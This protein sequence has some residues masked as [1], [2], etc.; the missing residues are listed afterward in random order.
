MSGFLQGFCILYLPLVLYLKTGFQ[1]HHSRPILRPLSNE[2]KQLGGGGAGGWGCCDPGD[3]RVRLTEDNENSIIC[4]FC[5]L[6]FCPSFNR[7]S[8]KGQICP[9]RHRKGT[10]WRH[11]LKFLDQVGRK[12]IWVCIWLRILLYK[13]RAK[14]FKKIY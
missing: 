1:G 3:L 2:T 13:T 5:S 11:M 12:N 10:H 4:T 9:H 7:S 8:L 6:L 14:H